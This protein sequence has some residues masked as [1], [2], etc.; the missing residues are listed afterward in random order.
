[1][2]MRHDFGRKYLGKYFKKLIVFLFTNR[3]IIS[4]IGMALLEENYIKASWY[5]L[6]LCFN[7]R[8]RY[9]SNKKKG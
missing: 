9:L 8:E 1:M 7:E 2:G 3:V 4:Y 6:R 5:T